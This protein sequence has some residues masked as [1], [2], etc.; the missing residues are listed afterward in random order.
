MKKIL[1]TLNKF[2]GAVIAINI[3]HQIVSSAGYLVLDQPILKT[4]YLI[5]I[6]IFGIE[7][8]FRIFVERKLSFLLSIDGL[9]LINQLFF[10]IY[11]LKI[12]RLFRIKVSKG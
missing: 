12:L 6:G 3:L 11:D 4:L 10:S 8:F 7:L 9:V 1:D 5:S 2:F